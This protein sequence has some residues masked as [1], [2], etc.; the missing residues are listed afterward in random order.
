MSKKHW[1]SV[2]RGLSEDPK[3]RQAMGEAIWLFMHMIDSADWETGVIYEWRD[4]STAADMSLS[5]ATVR[6]WRDRLSDKGYITC[7]Q[8]QHGLEI[9]IH[10]WIDPR[11]YSGKKMNVRQGDMDVSPSE[12]DEENEV[13]TQVDIQVDTQALDESIV[14][15]APFIQPTPTSTPTSKKEHAR[16]FSPKDIEASN[17]KVDAILEQ[18]RKAQDKIASGISW[19]GRDKIPEPI[20]ELLDVYVQ[21]TGQKP[22]KGSLVDWLS[23]GQDWLDVGII[24]DDLRSAY[25]KAH[26]ATGEGF[27]V[28]RP[29]SLTKVAGMF[30]GERNQ[31]RSSAAVQS[32]PFATL[33]AYKERMKHAEAGR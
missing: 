27:M 3:H 13:D 25:K 31:R 2:K 24:G 33:N 11:N 20:R 30:A 22:S 28:A 23:T 32:D 19:P 12:N 9:V 1:I 26:P 17:K 10:N 4:K 18:E 8:K 29:G 15:P 7:C 21:L 5:S 14:N 6:S 16:E